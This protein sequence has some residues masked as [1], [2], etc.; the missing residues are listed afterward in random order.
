MEKSPSW[1]INNR[2]A[3]QEIPRLLWNPK[4]HYRFHNILPLVP[5]PSQI[6]PVHN[7]LPYPL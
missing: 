7:F 6:N 1:V 5:I 2:S 3:G 4:V